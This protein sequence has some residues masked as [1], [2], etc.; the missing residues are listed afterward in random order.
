MTLNLNGPF[1]VRT[2]NQTDDIIVSG[3]LIINK[4]VD[5]EGEV[6]VLTTDYNRHTNDFGG[7]ET[8]RTT[9]VGTENS[10]GFVLNGKERQF[11]VEPTT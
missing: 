1:L 2:E 7:P 11:E 5:M 9:G 3:P 6:F 10:G 8:V 4:P